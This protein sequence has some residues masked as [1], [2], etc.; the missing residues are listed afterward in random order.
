MILPLS[1]NLTKTIERKIMIYRYIYNGVT[2]PPVMI[3]QTIV[4]MIG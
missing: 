4:N 3:F 2:P 1:G